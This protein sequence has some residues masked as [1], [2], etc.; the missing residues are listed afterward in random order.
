MVRGCAW[1]G[2]KT[3]ALIHRCELW[4]GALRHVSVPLL[5]KL[6]SRRSATFGPQ[7][8][9]RDTPRCTASVSR[10]TQEAAPVAVV[11]RPSKRSQWNARRIWDGRLGNSQCFGFGSHSSGY[12]EGLSSRRGWPMQMQEIEKPFGVGYWAAASIAACVARRSSRA[13][14]SSR[15]PGCKSPKVS[16]D[17]AAGRFRRPCFG[18]IRRLSQQ[19]RLL[20]N[21]SRL[22]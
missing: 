17:P 13:A 6:P 11:E 2:Q 21:S 1:S 15:N 19:R 12:G 16:C 22:K 5:C 10:T 8:V 14:P 4:M 7:P 18:A 3:F 9:G 20:S